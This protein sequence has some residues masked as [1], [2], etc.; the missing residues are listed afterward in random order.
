MRP[1]FR[2]LT[3]SALA[4]SVAGCTTPN[5][6]PLDKQGDVPTGFTAPITSTAP[7]WPETTWW[8]NFKADE[9]GPLEDTAQKENLDLAA[10]AARVIQAEAADTIAFSG[11]LPTASGSFGASRGNSTSFTT[12]NSFSAGF[13]AG[14]Q[15]NF[16]G[17]QFDQLQAARESLRAARYAE[18]VVGLTVES[19]VANQYFTV[20]SLRERL[21]IANRNIEAAKRILA[22]TQ[23]K[24][25]SGVSSN[26]D[27]AEQQAVV[28]QQESRLPG[29]IEQE[30]EA[31]YALA[32]LMGRAPEGFDVKAQNLDNITSPVVRPGLPS[33][34]LLRLP[35]I[36]EAEANLYAAHAN[37]DAARAA[38]F[39]SL[40]LTSA[41]GWASSA[42]GSLINPSNFVWN[43]GASVVQSIFDGGR[44]KAE[45]DQAR[46][47]ETELLAD[48]RKAV[49]TDFG[50]VESALGTVQ[51]TAD[52]LALLD[53]EV[54]ADAEAFRISELQY[55][56]G[57]IDILSLLTAQQNLFAAQDAFVQTKLARLE[58]NIGLYT[59]LGG[60]WT[61]AAADT[62][63]QPQLDWWPL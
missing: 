16:F 44:I 14:Y 8:A 37:V 62:A 31:R 41:A 24:V 63:Y 15:Q 3:A 22:I 30:R 51:A 58:A 32:I 2:S 60:G 33:E 1:L 23:A 19:E 20:L 42:I 25:S 49:F 48:Y 7:I 13:S 35:D 34:L 28:A 26:L 27:L 11:L 40:S 46:A 61:Q 6:T 29:L 38:F 21:T 18:T 4:L 39:P 47:R 56:E 10:A 59:A 55:R 9:L 17:Q 5:P 45:S 53:A 12:R 57:T 52:Q 36:A 43:I 50:Q 54:K